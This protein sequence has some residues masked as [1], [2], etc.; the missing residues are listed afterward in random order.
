MNFKLAGSIVVTVGNRMSRLEDIN[1]EVTQA[2]PNHIGYLFDHLFN[3]MS[4]SPYFESNTQDLTTERDD[5]NGINVEP[6]TESD[7]NESTTD[8]KTMEERSPEVSSG[9]EPQHTPEAEKS[10]KVEP[11]KAK[12]T[13]K[14]K[15]VI[16][17]RPKQKP[18][19]DTEVVETIH[20]SGNDP[21]NELEENWDEYM[22]DQKRKKK[23]HSPIKAMKRKLI[24]IL[25]D[26]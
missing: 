4:G 19:P 16:E 24:T 2:E 15:K 8:N 18:A 13:I 26:K 11:L 5:T 10:V 20:V 17:L 22:R 25:E 14:S 23:K 12:T 21:S 9:T 1:M 3:S 7:S 6:N